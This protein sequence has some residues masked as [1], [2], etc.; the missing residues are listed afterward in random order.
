MQGGGMIEKQNYR[1]GTYHLRCL[2]PDL[3]GSGPIPTGLVGIS[4][5]HLDHNH[6]RHR[7][8][9]LHLAILESLVSPL[10]I[11]FEAA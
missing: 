8:K 1:A 2:G 7:N 4:S 5:T 3:C 11:Y 6:H 9:V 10:K